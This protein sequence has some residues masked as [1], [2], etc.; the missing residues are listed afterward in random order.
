VLTVDQ[1]MSNGP[2]L[3][4]KVVP[5]GGVVKVTAWARATRTELARMEKRILDDEIG[6]TV[7]TSCLAV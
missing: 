2:L 6:W 4:S 1:V 3:R 7:K 5:L